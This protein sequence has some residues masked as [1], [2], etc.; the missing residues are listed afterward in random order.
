[1]ENDRLTEDRFQ[2]P[3]RHVHTKQSKSITPS[4]TTKNSA[5][6][7]MTGKA[8]K[9]LA[10]TAVTPVKQATFQNSTKTDDLKSMHVTD[11]DPTNST[12]QVQEDHVINKKDQ[13]S[14]IYAFEDGNAIN[15]GTFSTNQMMQ[16][17]EEMTGT[18]EILQETVQKGHVLS[19]IPPGTGNA[20]KVAS[21]HGSSDGYTLVTEGVKQVQLTQSGATPQKARRV[22][23]TPIYSK[24]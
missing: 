11:L 4:V 18:D 1:M 6:A 19:A 22:V 3:V 15:M 17:Q 13:K 9:M 20:T 8:S 5:Y 21:S 2:T 16:S 10:P 24:S 23:K 7:T 14:P 12:V